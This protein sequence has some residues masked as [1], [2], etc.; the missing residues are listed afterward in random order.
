MIKIAPGSVEYLAF[1]LTDVLPTP[2]Q[3]TS[4]VGKSPHF[5]VYATDEAETQV[6]AST[7]ASIANGDPLIALCLINATIPTPFP[8]EGDYNLF[9]T[10]SN[11][12]ESPRLG[13][14]RFRVDD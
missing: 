2:D 10:F 11:S 8:Q 3:L 7:A 6:V 14:F 9:F 5:E 12:P 1:K 4:L 13:P